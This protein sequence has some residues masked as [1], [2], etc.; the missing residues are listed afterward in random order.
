MKHTCR[1]FPLS[2]SDEDNCGRQDVFQV[3]S[4]ERKAL[5]WIVGC[6]SDYMR[7]P[8]NNPFR[9]TL[10]LVVL[11]EDESMQKREQN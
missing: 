11:V 1:R 4:F 9:Q 5:S 2:S 7:T 6:D 10:L 8:G 3:L